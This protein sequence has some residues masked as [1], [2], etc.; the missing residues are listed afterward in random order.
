MR[1]LER[2]ILSIFPSLPMEG[3]SSVMLQL[4]A[5]SSDRLTSS[6]SWSGRV[7]RG[8]SQMFRIVNYLM[9][10]THSGRLVK[11]FPDRLMCLTPLSSPNSFGRSCSY[12]L[13]SIR[14]MGRMYCRHSLAFRLSN[15]EGDILSCSFHSLDM[16]SGTFLMGLL[17]ISSLSRKREQS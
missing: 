14:V 16:A 5:I 6:S 11:A 3:G 12:S 8:C 4:L 17:S 15:T 10:S 7:Y 9:W 1:L 13:S 2:L